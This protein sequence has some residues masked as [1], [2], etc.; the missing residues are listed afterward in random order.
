MGHWD[1]QYLE[2]LGQVLANV[3]SDVSI[4]LVTLPQKIYHHVCEHF[5]AQV[6]PK[7]LGLMTSIELQCLKCVFINQCEAPGAFDDNGPHVWSV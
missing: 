3:F 5:V 7:Q 4:H 6:S 2:V 1:T